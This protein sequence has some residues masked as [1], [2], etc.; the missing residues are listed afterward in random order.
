MVTPRAAR[1]D[2]LRVALLGNA[3][4]KVDASGRSHKG[5][6]T[7]ELLTVVIAHHKAITAH[8]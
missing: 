2:L 1:F 8:L 5:A 6:L 3:P 4:T 7:G